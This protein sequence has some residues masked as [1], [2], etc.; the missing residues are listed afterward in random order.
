MDTKHFDNEQK[1]IY[2]YLLS[3]RIENKKAFDVANNYEFTI[4]DSFEDFVNYHIENYGCKL[5]EFVRLDWVQMWRES[6][7][8]EEQYAL[9]DAREDFEPCPDT[10][11]TASHL[12]ILWEEQFYE[13][14]NVSRFLEVYI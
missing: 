7:M 12:Y 1:E 6:F 8:S 14:I 9:L 2:K 4:Y 11:D 5:P 3:I 13:T 10:W